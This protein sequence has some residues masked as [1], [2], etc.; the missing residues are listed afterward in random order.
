LEILHLKQKLN[1]SEFEAAASDRELAS[2][3]Q[4]LDDQLRAYFDTYIVDQE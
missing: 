2:I 4:R 1:P 3:R